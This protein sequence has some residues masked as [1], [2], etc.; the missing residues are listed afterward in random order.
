MF[1]LSTFYAYIIRI[2][3]A[4]KSFNNMYNA[5]LLSSIQYTCC[6]MII[7]HSYKFVLNHK[8]GRKNTNSATS[9]EHTYKLISLRV[10]TKFSIS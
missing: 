1:M 5:K 2:D 7:Y 9:N 10:L 6:F 3:T 8:I 4:H